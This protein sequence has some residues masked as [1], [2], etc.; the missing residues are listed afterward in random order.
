MKF[1][2]LNKNLIRL[3]VCAGALSMFMA[4]NSVNTITVR[5]TDIDMDS[6]DDQDSSSN[7]EK[8]VE[9]YESYKADFDMYE[10]SIDDVFFFYCNVANGS[11]TTSPVKFDFPKNI[12]YSVEK[13]GEAVNYKAGSDITATGNYV[14]RLTGEYNGTV[15]SSTFRFSK[16][17]GQDNNTDNNTNTDNNN[18]N[19]VEIEDEFQITE[20]DLNNLEDEDITDEEIANMI[21]K[22]GADM[23]EEYGGMYNTNGYDVDAYSGLL[24]EFNSEAGMY[25]YTFKSGET[26]TCNVPNGALINNAV[27]L[28]AAADV[29]T[30][31]Y[32][33]GQLL[34]NIE[35][36]DFREEGTYLVKFQSTNPAFLRFYPDEKSYPFITF[37]I[38]GKAQRDIEIFTAPKGCKIISIGNTAG[39]FK[40]PETEDFN[41]NLDYYWL[42]ESGTYN[43]GVY[44]PVADGTY[45]VTV[46]RDL[47]APNVDVSTTKTSA[48][49]MYPD[50]DVAKV[51]VYNNGQLVEYTN[52][53][54]VGKGN[55]YVEFYDYA[56]NMTTA[57]FSLKDGFNSGDL[58]AILLVIALV[59]GGFVYL[60][61]ERTVMRVR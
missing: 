25:V 45:Y 23:A 16:R 49:F 52:G 59:F 61:L 60:R 33:D 38:L 34:E 4:F 50:A 6:T 44:D 30:T 10:E 46:N 26:V 18:N 28:R 42:P 2:S 29:I 21:D 43:F 53:P 1:H 51:L 12:T 19:N 8:K 39:L 24:Q 40:N 3:G 27:S 35:Y 48:S 54:V 36:L 55:Y 5:A 41:F 31:V 58:V 57:S 11:M 17:E 47:I 13:D 7:N 22:A 9:L 14:I 15:Y 32:K 20:E 56:G 37:R